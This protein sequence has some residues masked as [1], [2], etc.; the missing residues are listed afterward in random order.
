MK[1][2]QIEGKSVAKLFANAVRSVNRIEGQPF[3]S[4]PGSLFMLRITI[5]TYDVSMKE[6]VLTSPKKQTN[7]QTNR[8]NVFFFYI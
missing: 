8:K 1:I 6:Q 4:L 5:H 2:P 7:K 3:R